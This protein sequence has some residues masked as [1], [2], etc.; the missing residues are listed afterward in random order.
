[1]LQSRD[2][3]NSIKETIG[4][5][6]PS[7]IPE[8]KMEIGRPKLKLSYV[9]TINLPTK[10]DEGSRKKMQHSQVW[11]LGTP[12]YWWGP[13]SQFK[14]FLDRW[15]SVS[16]VM[17]QGR[18]VVL[19]IP[20]GGGSESYARHTVG[21]LT[22]VLSYLGMEHSATILAPGSNGRSTVKERPYILEAARDAGRM[23]AHQ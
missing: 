1:M 8:D 21:M 7:Y 18:K 9:Y 12:I 19:A 20:L 14:A 17:F 15:Y 11:V 6:S 2:S 22:D 10:G 16:Q 5:V 3:I 23:A 4:K 13:T